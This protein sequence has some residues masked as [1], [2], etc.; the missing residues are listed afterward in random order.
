MDPADAAGPD[1]Y[2]TTSLGDDPAEIYDEIL[3][4]PGAV[5]ELLTGAELLLSG[6]IRHWIE[7]G[8]RDRA[9]RLFTELAE[10]GGRYDGRDGGRDGGSARVVLALFAIIESRPAEADQQLAAL[11][12]DPDLDADHCMV[13]AEL[14]AANGDPRGALEWYDRHVG[15]L[16]PERIAAM[17][18][19][20]GW[21]E[22][23]TTAVTGRSELRRKLRLP[24]DATDRIA[25]AARVQ[26]IRR[27]KGE[28]AARRTQERWS[29]GWPPEG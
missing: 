29:S 17:T 28:E 14:L 24:P 25:L 5:F 27:F 19:P 3:A 2:P 1:E 8:A 6:A 4:R 13:A 18:G 23:L 12:S 16:G 11:A 7:T 21:E 15:L 10:Q 9:M 20:N 22:A 26:L